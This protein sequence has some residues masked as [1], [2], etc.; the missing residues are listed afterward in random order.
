[1]RVA[2]ILP[3]S[4]GGL[5]RLSN[6]RY[7]DFPSGLG[8]IAACLRDAGHTAAIFMPDP[9]W[10]PMKRVWR[11]L[12]SFK[13]DLV[14]VSAFTQNFMEARRVIA[15]AK[16]RCACPVILGGPH[17]T[18]LPRSTLQG[19]PELD[20]IILGEG[21]LPVLALAAGFAKS[22]K[23]DLENIPGA[24]FIKDGRYTENPRPEP[25]ADLD[26]LPYPALDLLNGGG[27]PYGHAKIMTSRGCPGQCN[28]CANICMGRKFR[29]HSP[30]RVVAE[31]E[32]LVKT[33]GI[34]FLHIMDDCFT[35]DVARVHRICDLLIAKK[36]KIFWEAC[37]RVNTLDEAL[38]VKMKQAGCM[39]LELGIET[40][41]QR[42]N[43]LMGKGT[44]LEMA[45]KACALLRRHDV[46]SLTTFI[47][48][49]DGETA[50]T[51]RETLALSRRLKSTVSMFTT[52]IPYPG[53]GIFEKYYKEFDK[54]DT[55]WTGWCAQGP[56]RPYEPRQTR[57]SGATLW[58]NLVWA[59]LSYFLS[60]SQ[61]LRIGYAA[62]K[63]FRIG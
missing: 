3:L 16:R 28:F 24:A 43:N 37:A 4:P 2:L 63:W 22:G 15:E 30:E 20:A 9:I 45:E 31:I 27:K 49:N 60:P 61:L 53:T 5:R 42:L 50:E 6:T 36:I 51:L 23:V 55:D 39:R 25:I 14:G 62:F 40:G 19:L 29:P 56:F 47:I 17:A 58:R 38:L 12:E 13:P 11:E 21:E 33:Y 1:M 48:G 35:A 57:L 46:D 32:H 8:Y 10:M 44:T 41:S 7:D 26:S 52:L 18:A 59:Y 54:P 34:I